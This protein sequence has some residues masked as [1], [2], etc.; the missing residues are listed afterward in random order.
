MEKKG[1]TTARS[2]PDLP[3]RLIYIRANLT[4]QGSVE[5]LGEC[6]RNSGRTSA[7][8]NLVTLFMVGYF[9]LK[10]IYKEVAKRDTFRVLLTLFAVNHLVHFFFI[11][12]YFQSQGSALEVSH[13]LH[14]TIT[15]ICLLS[16]PIILWNMDRLNKVLYYAV[17]LHLFNITYFICKTFYSR[18]KPVDPAYLHQL[19]IVIMI[20]SL[21]YIIYRMYRERSVV[22]ED[23][24]SS[25]QVSGSRSTCVPAL[26]P[27]Q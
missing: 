27:D 24:T 23:A 8:L 15:F 2:A 6:A 9:G 17:I 12:Q 4:L 19:G 10:T 3:E 7:A 22:F 11:H 14:G 26:G 13:N 16:L 21:I 5:V 1:F 18:Y 25:V 20:G